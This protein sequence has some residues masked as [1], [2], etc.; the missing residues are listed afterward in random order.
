MSLSI[1]SGRKHF[2]LG[3]ASFLKAFFSTVVLQL[4]G[5]RWGS[6]YPIIMRELYGGRLAYDRA[7]AAL[8]ELEQLRAALST[9]APDRVVWDFENL[10]AKPPWGSAISQEIKSMDAYF[11]TSDGRNLLDVLGAALKEAAQ[12]HRD[13]E[14][15]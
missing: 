15:R 8:S 2:E 1:W 3:S 6:K 12:S 14:I 10:S 5:G 9:L 13:L 4:E 11:V 7:D